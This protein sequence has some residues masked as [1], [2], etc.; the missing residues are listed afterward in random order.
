VENKIL[1]KLL[2]LGYY[3]GSIEGFLNGLNDDQVYF[4]KVIA[5]DNNQDKRVFLLGKVSQTIYHELLDLLESTQSKPTNSVWMPSWVFENGKTQINV[6][7]LL[8]IGR[9][10]LE[11]PALLVLGED[12]LDEITI[13]HSTANELEHATALVAQSTPINLE[14][15]NSLRKL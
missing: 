13:L 5:W 14:N 4:F 1:T 11:T 15:W 10:S 7:K 6:N 9:L 3:D 12:L 8:Q 2:V